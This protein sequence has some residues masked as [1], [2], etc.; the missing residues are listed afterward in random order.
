[1][2]F[3]RIKIATIYIK[4]SLIFLF[5]FFFE[6]EMIPCKKKKKKKKNSPRP[7]FS[8]NLCVHVYMCGEKNYAIRHCNKFS[9]FSFP[10][11]ENCTYTWS[12]DDVNRD[13]TPSSRFLISKV[14]MTRNRI[15][16]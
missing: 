8:I 4:S 9:F 3:A 13:M 1:M 10:R 7:N 15:T 11:S 5:L 14:S 12:S 6:M 16:I 2:Q